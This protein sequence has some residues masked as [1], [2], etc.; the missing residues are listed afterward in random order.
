M[1][2]LFPA[3][4]D[5]KIFLKNI[6][7]GEGNTMN[8]YETVIGNQKEEIDHLNGENDMITA[9]SEVCRNHPRQQQIFH[10][11]KMLLEAGYPYYFNFWEELRPTP[12]EQNGRNPEND[13]DWDSF[14]FIIEIGRQVETGYAQISVTFDH[15]GNGEL[16]EL[17]DMREVEDRS[18][19]S[20][21]DGELHTGLTSEQAMEI[22]E[23]FFETV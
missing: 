4:I 15:D 1:L 18:N 21:S 19:P 13:I 8:D 9:R 2:C 10:L 12:F 3:E 23:K 6:R 22:I 16:L 7:K 17:L 5:S 20:I 14:N 11:E